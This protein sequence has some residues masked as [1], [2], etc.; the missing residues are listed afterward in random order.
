ML[1]HWVYL[2]TGAKPGLIGETSAA[3]ALQQL[4]PK[5]FMCLLLLNVEQSRSLLQ[6]VGLDLQLVAVKTRS[7]CTGARCE[8]Y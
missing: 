7:R 5:V 6:A 1:T 4:L 2:S 3:L 8:S